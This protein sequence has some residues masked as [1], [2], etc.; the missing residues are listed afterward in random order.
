[1]QLFLDPFD[2]RALESS[3]D[4]LVENL[5]RFITSRF[6][7][8]PS[9]AEE[10]A[11]E[12]MVVIEWK[13]RYGD[14]HLDRWSADDAKSFLF[15]WCPRQLS[16]IAEESSFALDA[17][18]RW[19]DF[20]ASEG[21]FVRVRE[22]PSEIVLIIESWRRNFHEAM[23]DPSLFG[24]AK[25]FAM[26]AIE[27]GIDLSDEVALTKYLEN[28]NSDIWSDVD[29]TMHVAGAARGHVFGTKLPPVIAPCEAEISASILQ[30]PVLAM[31]RDFAD[32][33]GSGRKLTQKGNL[34]LADARQLVALL[35]TG[36]A[37]EHRYGMSVSKITSSTE[38]ATLDAVF[39]WAKKAGFVR[40]LHGKVVACKRG[41]AL[42]DDLAGGF[43][44]AVEA[45]MEIGPSSLY[46][47]HN[48]K[49]WWTQLS[50]IVDSLS[51]E[52][53]ALP[54]ASP[55]P[56]E[57]ATVALFIGDL[58]VSGW[59]VQFDEDQVREWI[60]SDVTAIVDSFV[61]C[62]LLRRE[63]N[64]KTHAWR[65]SEGGVVTVTPAGSV[66]ARRLLIDAGFDAPL[67]GGLVDA[68][69]LELLRAIEDADGE[70]ALGEA[71]AWFRA[72]SPEAAIDELVLALYE[73]NDPG[74]ENLLMSLVCELDPWRGEECLRGLRSVPKFAGA[75]AYWLHEHEFIDEDELYDAASAFAFV[76]T[77]ALSM[78]HDGPGGLLKSLALV[79]DASSQAEFIDTVWRAPSSATMVI[80]VAVSKLHPDKRVSKAAR[81]STF[82]RE[83]AR[84]SS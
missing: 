52:L 50:A 25:T 29:S 51:A 33:V 20:L 46:L 41:L 72:R 30:A 34:T 57:L 12:T 53:L 1:M 10:A 32:Y 54:Y 5:T 11:R 14:G 26:G 79:G 74:M 84:L 63:G 43:D 82:K 40:V 45:L 58:V 61:L 48:E 62:G 31:F 3:R 71:V 81:K 23:A 15:E 67:L 28:L 73:L 69:A 36:D 4:E 60:S 68:S 13:W 6:S 17:T 9:E 42:K 49:D 18:V 38:L 55:E 2:D 24:P 70:I 56:V 22:N 35:D 83:S 7:L 8:A 66:T 78:I 21:R 80:L 77:L 65:R 37:L 47:R 64:V 76:D 75:A 44:R 27:S 19:I 39:S 16:V 59:S